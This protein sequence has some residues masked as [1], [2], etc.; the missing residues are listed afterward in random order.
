MTIVIQVSFLSGIQ[1]I[2]PSA[3]KQRGTFNKLD[4]LHDY[5]VR[6]DGRKMTSMLPREF[7]S[8]GP[9]EATGTGSF[10]P[11]SADRTAQRGRQKEDHVRKRINC[12][13][14]GKHVSSFVEIMKDKNSISDIGAIL[15]PPS[16]SG[17]VGFLLSLPDD[18]SAGQGH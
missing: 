11:R 9:A 17:S 4:N 18:S 6:I 2:V 7:I 16:P 1:A 10:L 5:Q 15:P 3:Y 12:Q 13:G 8:T 14:G